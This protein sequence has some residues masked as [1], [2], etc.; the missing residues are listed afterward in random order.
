M[1][2]H[3]VGGLDRL[4]RFISAAIIALVGLFWVGGWVGSVMVVIALLLLVTG[5]VG[6]CPAYVPFGISTCGEEGKHDPTQVAHG[7]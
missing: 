3:N 6:F 5:L 2:K 4:V 7:T 1:S